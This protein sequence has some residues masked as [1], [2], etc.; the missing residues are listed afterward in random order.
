MASGA[1]SSYAAGVIG[2]GAEIMNAERRSYVLNLPEWEL[3]RIPAI[4][5]GC[6]ART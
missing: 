4:L 3:L 6:S 5:I 1:P 2:H